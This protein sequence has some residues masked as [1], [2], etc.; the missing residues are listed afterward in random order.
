MESETGSAVRLPSLVLLSQSERR[1]SAE[2]NVT[3]GHQQVATSKQ[4][5]AEH[6]P[7]EGL[8]KRSGASDRKSS[9]SS[10]GRQTDSRSPRA[11]WP[12]RP[13]TMAPARRPHSGTSPGRPLDEWLPSAA[14]CR[15]PAPTWI[16]RR[17]VENVPRPWADVSRPSWIHSPRAG[18]ELK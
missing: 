12:P 18:R 16:R 5:A 8:T 13:S 1:R 15:W 11:T 14:R 10:A 4:Q 6:G 17:R 2:E 7:R 3:C 9:I